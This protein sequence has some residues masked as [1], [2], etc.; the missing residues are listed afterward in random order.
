MALSR[1]RILAWTVAAAASPA[2]VLGSVHL[3]AKAWLGVE[4]KTWIRDEPAAAAVLAR[5][6]S[7]DADATARHLIELARPLGI[8]LGSFRSSEI[9]FGSVVAFVDGERRTLAD[10]GDDAPAEVDEHLRRVNGRLDPVEELLAASG[11]PAWPLHPR[12]FDSNDP[13]ILGLRDLNALLLARA[14]ERSRAGDRSG[15]ERALLSTVRLGDSLRERPEVLAQIGAIWIASARAGVLRRLAPPPGDGAGRL[16]T[17]DFRSSVLV[18]LQLEARLQLEHSRRQSFAWLGL[19]RTDENARGILPAVD[20]LLSTPFARGC[21]ADTSR[22]LR[23]LAARWRSTEPCRVETAAP[24]PVPE[25]FRWNRIARFTVPAIAGAWRHVADVELEEELTRVVLETR[26][27]PPDRR[28]TLASR[29][30]SGLAWTRTPDANG[31]VTVAAE[32]VALPARRGG[33][34]W[35]YR[36]AAPAGQR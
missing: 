5:L 16:G 13:P 7:A 9:D 15:T 25:A 29:V 28:D 24:S 32:G 1:R 20:R 18:S 33:V 26:A 3:V 2:V 30:C 19:G 31:A 14:V 11:P 17:H 34:P 27:Q 36:V 4:R 22:R 35:S 21:G 12:A 23:D 10:A 6:R 8:E